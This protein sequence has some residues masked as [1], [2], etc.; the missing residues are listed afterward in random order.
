MHCMQAMFV[1]LGLAQQIPAPCCS[2][3]WGAFIQTC[4]AETVMGQNFSYTVVLVEESKPLQQLLSDGANGT[5]LTA[6][7][8]E[9]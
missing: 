4:V 1:D 3:V 6:A 9:V 8:G 7:S 5:F 2:W